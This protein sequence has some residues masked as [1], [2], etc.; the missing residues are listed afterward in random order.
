MRC[1]DGVF[2]PHVT[3]EPSACTCATAACAVINGSGAFQLGAGVNT[4][5]WREVLAP[6]YGADGFWGSGSRYF[7]VEEGLWVN[8]GAAV[9]VECA[10]GYRSA[11][12]SLSHRAPA[13]R[14]S[15][16][17]NPLAEVSAQCD[18]CVLVFDSV[19]VKEVRL[20]TA[21]DHCV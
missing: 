9:R 4:S 7:G 15:T 14:N 19:C 10:A 2:G 12:L 21:F 8:H 20:T 3:C 11:P 17:T 5:S 13:P 16:C 1:V 18:A 6:P